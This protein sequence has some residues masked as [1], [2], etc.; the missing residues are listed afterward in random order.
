MI[1]EAALKILNDAGYDAVLFD[2]R[3]DSLGSLVVPFGDD[4]DRLGSDVYIEP[5]PRR[6]GDRPDDMEILAFSRPYPFVFS[7]LDAVSE[8]IR[9]ILHLNRLLPIGA[10]QFAEEIP[11]I[12]FSYHLVTV[13]IATID[14][15][16]LLDSLGMVAFFS[17]LHG[18]LIDQVAHGRA[19]ADEV[20]AELEK[21][22]VRPAPVFTTA[23]GEVK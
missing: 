23:L 16:V 18:D 3:A 7:D 14:K 2:D 15:N 8:T 19:E 10:H 11:A 12:Y 4:E 22:G 20:I 13:S 9:L 6:D 21:I 17:D 5:I 1:T